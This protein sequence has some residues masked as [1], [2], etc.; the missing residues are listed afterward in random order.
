M[1]ASASD[2]DDD[3]RVAPVPDSAVSVSER[4]VLVIRNECGVLTLRPRRRLCDEHK[5]GVG[6]LKLSVNT[7]NRCRRSR[8]RV[9]EELRRRR[10]QRH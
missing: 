3:G 2:G 7:A 5:R 9:T 8:L 10:G 4:H 6:R 1:L